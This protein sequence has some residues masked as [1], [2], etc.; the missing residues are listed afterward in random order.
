[1]TDDRTLP[2]FPTIETER[3]RL[4]PVAAGD[5]DPL[6]ERRNDPATAQWQSWA[7]PYTRDQAEQLIDQI[8]AH[9]GVPPAEGWFQISV[10]E[11]S[12]G[13]TIG[14][15]ALHLTFGGRCAEL[16][17]TF[18]PAARG[19]GYATEAAAAL[20]AWCVDTLGVSRVSAQ[21]HPDNVA[22]AR[23]AEHIG[24]EFEG[25]TRNSFWVDHADGSAENSDDVIYGM[26]DA[27]WRAW[28]QRV[29]TPPERVRL[30][31]L[32][33][34][35]IDAVVQLHTHHSQRDL[36]SSNAESIIDAYE[37]EHR[38]DAT[39]V[40]WLRAITADDEP[41]GFVM[42][43]PPKDDKTDTYLWRLMID[44]RHQRRGIGS[45]AIEQVVDQA[46]TWQSTAV[47]V[48]WVPGP[49]SPEP[50]YRR[51]GFAPTGVVHDGEVVAQ[52][53]L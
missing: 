46:R 31:E 39:R 29:R 6:H 44:R 2:E 14:D 9:D 13:H 27:S 22:S 16:G 1:M 42:V 7:L 24:M 28:R 8:L 45:H 4:R 26:T 37:A 47:T 10:D 35:M 21:M 18:A 53:D 33:A 19:K 5:V 41:V 11:Q 12:T 51:L 40:P 49:G 50:V 30:V 17:Y 25:R 38:P 43:A 20:T 52:L 32:D 23:V 34:E 48:S 36:V 15:L 3:L